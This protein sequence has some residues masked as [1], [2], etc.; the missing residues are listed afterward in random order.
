M[1]EYRGLEG[2]WHDLFWE[3]EE[4][5]ELPLL[6]RFLKETPHGQ[7][8]YIGSG[9]GRLLGPLSQEGFSLLGI[10][11]S[12]EMVMRSQKQWPQAEVKVV[13]WENFEI[14][15]RYAAI[16][17]PAF[18]LQLLEHPVTALK[19][20]RKAVS[21]DGRLYLSLFF[22]WIELSGELPSGK[23]WYEDR[24][25]ELPDGRRA[26]I[27]T[28]HQID[29]NKATL[30]REHRYRL[31]DARGEVLQ[32][33][34]TKQSLRWFA[35]GTLERM[36]AKSGWKISKEIPNFEEENGDDDLVYVVTLECEA[37]E[38]A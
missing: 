27:W 8:L 9:S 21:E 4:L 12:E 22:P 38:R 7:V 24:E 13:R 2:E 20:M 26:Q 6:R 15:E 36:L 11:A 33:Q 28:R 37:G 14:D 19:K 16:V 10:E 35:D 29:E 30:R 31:L 23:K 1:N 25:L 3:E 17:V 5:S 34:I 32:E 18:T